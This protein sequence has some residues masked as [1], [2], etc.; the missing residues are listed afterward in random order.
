MKVSYNWIKDY[1]DIDLSPEVV[2]DMLTDTGLEVEGIEQ[3][4]SVPGGLEGLVIGEV[5][6]KVKHPDADR[7]NVTKVNVG[8]GEPLSIVCGA[9][10]VDAGQKV[11]VAT[12]GSMLYPT[13]GDSFKIKKSKIRGVESFGMICAE[14]EIGLGTDHDGIMVLDADA[15]VGSLARDYFELENDYVFDI[16]LTPNRADSMGHIGVARDLAAAIKFHKPE[17]YSEVKW[18]S[19]DDFKV[20]NTN[21]ITP[22]EVNDAAACPRYAG[23]TITGVKVGPSAEWLQKRL[24]AIGLK[25]INNIVD[26]TNFVLHELGH[27]MHAFDADQIAGDKVIVQQLPAG[28]KFVTLDDEERELHQD[29]LMICNSEGGMCIAGVFGGSKSGVSDATTNVFLESAY[30][31]PVSVRKT[32]KRHALNTDASFR[33]ERGI[34][35]NLSIMAIKR[36]AMLIKEM[37]G[38]EISSEISDFYPEPIQ[39][40]SVDFKYSHCDRLL[41]KA[42]DHDVIKGILA[43][44]DIEVVSENGDELKLSV[45]PYR[46]DVQREADV[47]EEVLRI[48]GFNNVEIPEQQTASLS[49][50]QKPDPEVVQHLIS[51]MLSSTGYAETMSNSL[52]SSKY[53]EYAEAA[54]VKEETHVHILNPLSNEL[55]VMRQTLLFSGLEAIAHNQNRQSLDLKLY[56]FGNVYRKFP[57]GYFENKRL[58][59][60]MC[61]RKEAEQ[62][63][64]SNDNVSFY[65]L[66][67][68]VNSVLQRL[69]IFKNLKT[70]AVKSGLFED[71]V[72]Y[73]IAKKKVVEFGWVKRS[74]LK[75]MDV[76]QD[77][78]FADFDWDAVVELLK[79]NRVKYTGIPKFPA[80]RRDLSLLIDKQVSFGEIE[81][82][83][84]QQER[85]LLKEVGLFDV[86]EGKNLDADKKSYAV[87]FILQDAEKTLTDKQIDKIMSKIQGALESQLGAQL[88]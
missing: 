39:P 37:A 57:D 13:G 83:A 88:R 61:G 84:Y 1:L 7:L 29:D 73:T 64:N 12:V 43:S 23:L 51:E 78:F 34:D 63:N 81:A 38:G 65:L 11:V 69:G 2:G 4:E 26:A 46:V 53:A 24:Q 5:L 48:Y 22:V 30:F 72:Q 77:V 28:T 20:D 16:G 17:L 6:E 14:D 56:E 62:W 70:G 85:G 18:P 32:A 67:G 42:I 52:T 47:I 41:G 66:K 86:Y 45:P 49:Y 59:I 87:N 9:P 19:V 80:V 35:P 33:Y 3:V 36:C 10:N 58:G 40:F 68:A 79:M 44:L 76:K 55:D 31:N 82:L 50:R 75:K 74:I 60:F 54:Q 27:P 8:N 25:P 71:G 21:R 15:K